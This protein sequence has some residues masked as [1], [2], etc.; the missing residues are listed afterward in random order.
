MLA[1]LGMPDILITFSVADNVWNEYVEMYSKI[2]EKNKTLYTMNKSLPQVQNEANNN[3][4]DAIIRLL[5][6]DWPIKDYWVSKEFQTRGS[7]HIH[8]IIY[9]DDKKVILRL[10]SNHQYLITKKVPTVRSTDFSDENQRRKLAEFFDSIIATNAETNS[11]SEIAIHPS[12]LSP[13]LG[14]YSKLVESL[15]IH[16]CSDYCINNEGKCKFEYPKESREKSEFLET[17]HGWKYEPK[18]SHKRSVPH[19]KPLLCLFRANMDI[20]VISS[21]QILVKYLTK[22]ITKT[23]KEYTGFMV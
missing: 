15:Q 19:N 12:S 23:S 22:Y 2:G 18:R 1:Q 3:M 16:A 8:G 5:L 9:F 6:D 13:S 10:M 11:D 21:V 7:L 20:A 17:M 4:L 14:N